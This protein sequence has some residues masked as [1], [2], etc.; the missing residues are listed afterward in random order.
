MGPALP[1]TVLIGW[2][3]AEGG[4]KKATMSLLETRACATGR[5]RALLWLAPCSSH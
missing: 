5:L 3:E 2:H 1:Q 4:F